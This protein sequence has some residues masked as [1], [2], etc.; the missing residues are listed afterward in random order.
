MTFFDELFRKNNLQQNN[1]NREKSLKRMAQNKNCQPD[2]VKN[3]FLN[4]L[5]SKNPS[6]NDVLDSITMF[7]ENKRKESNE[8]H[9]H[10]DDTCSAFMEQWAT[11]L[12]NKFEH[13]KNLQVFMGSTK[14]DLIKSAEILINKIFEMKMSAFLESNYLLKNTDLAS[15]TILD[16]LSKLK[17]E[18]ILTT[19]KDNE[20]SK[21]TGNIYLEDFE[22]SNLIEKANQNILIQILKI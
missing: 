2:E 4:E 21:K 6:K 12:Y 3:Q 5:L 13:Y 22:L 9:I 19:N 15:L 7:K 14:E 17:K 16:E 10:Q 20:L 8:F 1:F 18:I 11:E